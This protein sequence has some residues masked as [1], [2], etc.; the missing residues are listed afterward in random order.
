MEFPNAATAIVAAETWLKD[1]KTATIHHFKQTVIPEDGYIEISISDLV[2]H[3]Q[4]W[5][6]MDSVDLDEIGYDSIDFN[7]VMSAI[8]DA[9]DAVVAAKI[10]EMVE[11]GLIPSDEIY[12]NRNE[13]K[14]IFFSE[15]RT[16][17]I[18]H[19][20]DWDGLSEYYGKYMNP[21]RH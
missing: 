1:H 10:K 4:A 16:C 14:W 20:A 8:E 18:H 9:S 3:V 7:G 6:G 15:Y 11:G 5:T 13:K 19:S 17:I 12:A 2:E 21:V